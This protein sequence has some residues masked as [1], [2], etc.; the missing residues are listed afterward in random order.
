MLY[1]REMAISEHRVKPAD[2]IN[3]PSLIL[4]RQ[5]IH[6]L[7]EGYVVLLDSA[8]CWLTCCLS[9]ALLNPGNIPLCLDL[10][11]FPP[12]ITL[13]LQINQT[14]PVSIELI[15]FDLD[16]NANETISISPSQA[17][18]LRR[19]AEKA[20]GRSP[21][22][23]L[24]LQYQVK[25]TGLYRLSKVVDETNLEVQTR[26]SEALVVACPVARLKSP[27]ND[28]CRGDLSDLSIEVEGTPPLTVKYRKTVNGQNRDVSYQSIQPDDFVS[29]L[30]RQDAAGPLVLHEQTDLSWA[31]SYKTNVPLNETL[32]LSGKWFYS[33]DEVTDASGNKVVYAISEQ[34]SDRGKTKASYLE[35]TLDVH[36]RP[37]V[38]LLGCDLQRPLRVAEDE[39]V[40]LPIK[41]I[42][43]G[44][45]DL[46]NVEHRYSYLFTPYEDL[47]PNGEHSPNAK[48][49][50]DSIRN[51]HERILIKKAGLYTFQSIS[52]PRCDG[53]VMEPASC[54]LINP[55]KPDMA[56][57]HSEP[58]SDKC[59]GKAIGL[60]IDLDMTG[61]PPFV[62]Q[63]ITEK[64]GDEKQQVQ[65]KRFD[66]LRG[67]VE[68]RPES[69]GHYT[70]TFTEINDFVYKAIDLKH[71]NF[72]LEQDVKPSVS[73]SFVGQGQSKKGCIDQPAQ[74]DVK[75][76]GEGPWK[77]EYEIVHAG[78]RT[79][80][81]METT[82]EYS[83]IVTQ[84]LVSGGEYSIVLASVVD[85]NGCKEALQQ[86]RKIF[87][88][89]QRP[90]ASFGQIEKKL[91]IRALEGKPIDL[92]VR[93]S[94]E[95]PWQVECI[96]VHA[97]H[98]DS[99]TH[100]FGNANDHIRVREPGTYTLISVNDTSCLGTIDDAASTFEVVTIA[101][102]KISVPENALLEKIGEQYIR[103]DVC[104]GQEDAVDISFTGRP[105]FEVKYR[106]HVIPEHG[107]KSLR[108]QH[109]N[110]PLQQAQVKLD[111]SKAGV[112]KYVFTEL[113]DD[114]YEHDEEKH[115]PI[116]IQQKVNSRP[117]AAFGA[118]GKIYSFCVGD[119]NTSAEETVPLV[120]TGTPPFTVDIEIKHNSNVGNSAGKRS[121][122]LTAQL[123]QTLTIP[124]ILNPTYE[125]HIPSQY[126]KPGNSF[127]SIHRVRDALGCERTLEPTSANAASR[128]QI[129][130]HDPPTITP[131]D[132]ARSDY[133]VGERLAY[134]LSG[135]APFNVHYLFRGAER[136][137]SVATSTFRRLA[138]SAGN[139]TIL[140]VTDAASTCR[141]RAADV[142]TAVI[143]D[144]P[145]VRVSKGR[146]SR[147]DIH[148][149]GEA[150]ILFE[151]EGAPPF[152]FT[153]TRSEN[154][155][156]K[157]GREGR[158][159]ETRTLMSAERSL[160]LA[161]SEEGTY[162]V[163]A[164]RDLYCSF[165]KPGHEALRAKAGQKLLME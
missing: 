140:G 165:A 90:K 81:S 3:D 17:K 155:R 4:G 113:G 28:R 151:F 22:D 134:A 154:A 8:A 128:V 72:V 130:V 11:K 147:V 37:R 80:R 59:A 34:D 88:R 57:L 69:A 43:T 30:M 70:Y 163:V 21:Y 162:E 158:V 101:R 52:T 23:P 95:G 121:S 31:R 84:K 103:K 60:R 102:P 138:E 131:A 45:E 36:D 29:P 56:D 127:L 73:A 53:E 129:S 97:T 12:A 142:P 5:I 42:S 32:G 50:A 54:L 44:K 152:E 105:P 24:V 148:A 62:V 126:L 143:H 77:L 145:R 47:L 149:G 122:A 123:Q 109:M 16:T 6:V 71:K 41:Y 13:P 146:E 92:P 108:D 120:F 116:S 144:M 63:F 156:H 7:P 99:K 141:T 49:I 46:A 135:V 68:F 76:Q 137:A 1:D 94:G 150:Q 39:S 136:K 83:Q 75:L 153:Y 110:V 14:N 160:S 132:P 117:T 96:E 87:V 111:T 51:T 125:M 89:H 26:R 61:T 93:L 119:T 159:L 118:P 115:D 112:Y 48:L 65:T 91:S 139:F 107:S 35:E 15:R 2:I 85:K 79:K 27:G 74:F 157:G 161:A 67:H 82:E 19:E 64:R 10:R 133:C 100:R 20:P 55:P 38:S 66:S 33:I 78:K 86:E 106:E 9:S 40:V 114:N 98:N 58:I 164:V 25:K 104:E 124:N 18:K